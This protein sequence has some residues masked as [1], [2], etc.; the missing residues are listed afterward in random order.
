VPY[1][2]IARHCWCPGF[3]V[4]IIILTSCHFHT[5]EYNIIPLS[6]DSRGWDID[7]GSRGDVYEWQKISVTAVTAIHHWTGGAGALERACIDDM[8]ARRV[9][10][11]I[12]VL[13][14]SRWGPHWVW[15]LRI[16]WILVTLCAQ[17]KCYNLVPSGRPWTMWGLRSG[18]G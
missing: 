4:S 8:T 12:L 1:Y 9:S 11:K 6:F 7:R 10:A 3:D 18:D 2:A 5:T 13:T 15:L 17:R 16:S 14:S